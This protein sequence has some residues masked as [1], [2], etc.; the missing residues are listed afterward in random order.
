MSTYSLG[1]K[2]A[3]RP[4]FGWKRVTNANSIQRMRS[5]YYAQ[6]S[7]VQNPSKNVRS[8]PLTVYEDRRT[9]NPEGSTA[10]ARSFSSPRH[11]LKVSTPRRPENYRPTTYPWETVPVGIGFRNPS[12]VLVCVRRKMRREVL[13]AKKHAGIGG[14]QYK[15]HTNE[16]SNIHC[17]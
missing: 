15:H 2:Y 13:F 3:T 12:R 16:Y 4:W 17:Y 14:N 8:V 5:L 9:W 1:L 6:K 11:R 10:P 7:R